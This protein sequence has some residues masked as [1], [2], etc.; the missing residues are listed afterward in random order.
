MKKLFI[1]LLV[2]F[3]FFS[4]KI[5]ISAQDQSVEEITYKAKIKKK[6]SIDCPEEYS[7]FETCEKISIEIIEG[8]KKG[9]ELDIIHTPESSPKNKNLDYQKNDKVFIVETQIAGETNYYLEEP[10]R[11]APLTV[12]AILF[13]TIVVIIGGKKGASSLLGLVSTFL[14]I[15]LILIP[16]LLSGFNP[17]LSSL[18]GGILILGVSVYL[19]H[20]FGKKTTIALQGTII[21]L[22]ITTVL[23]FIY[24]NLAKLTGFSTDESTFLVQL[25]DKEINMKGILLSSLI[26]GSIGVLDDVT[27]SQVSLVFELSK[28]NKRF[29]LKELFAR[30]MKVGRDHISSMVNTLFLAYTSSAL[31]LIMLFIAAKASLEEIINYELIAEEIVRTLV[32]S[33]GLILAVPITSYLASSYIQKAKITPKS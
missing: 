16:L 2:L 14:V 28:A 32:G 21:S 23:A 10:F 15:R 29:D 24:T 9:E 3:A 26:I 19:S 7:Q 5:S 8:D 33:I 27:V 20:G 6:E 22:L 13:A 18:I 11:R 31:P 1:V 17:I 30:S 4:F 12:L 25:I